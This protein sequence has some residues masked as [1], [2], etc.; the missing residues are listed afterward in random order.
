[1]SETP[2]PLEAETNFE[3]VTFNFFARAWTV[4]AKRHFSHIKRMRDE[5][6]AGFQD[7]NVLTCE[8]L[9]NTE[10]LSALAAIDPD[11]D[12]LNEFVGEIAKAMGLGGSGNSKPSSASS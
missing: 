7:Y 3:T 5:L 6:Q 1:M 2:S 9:L 12:Q 8:T 4:P 11:E 10:Q